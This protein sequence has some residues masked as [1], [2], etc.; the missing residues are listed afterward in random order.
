MRGARLRGKLTIMARKGVRPGETRDVED[1]L[2]ELYATPPAEFVSLRERLAAEAR[3]DGRPE[4]ARR[5]HAARRPTLA[6]WAANLLLHAQ[7]QESGRFLELGRALREAYAGLDAEG[8][9]ELSQQRRSIVSALSRQAAELADEA[10]HRLSDAARQDVEGTLRAVL[11]DQEAADLW[12]AGRLES[13]LSPPTDF[14]SASGAPHGR[15][16]A[17]ARREPAR[18]SAGPRSSRSRTQDELAE[19]RRRRREQLDEARRAAADADRRLR[20][21]RAGQTEAESALHRARER[22][23]QARERQDAAEQRVRE[24]QQDLRQARQD[25]RQADR[26]LRTADEGHRAAGEAVTGAEREARDAERAVRRPAGPPS[27]AE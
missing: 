20:D 6:A 5:I 8:I 13:A 4:D 10:G 23:Q 16:A 18:A 9:K 1:V 12:A 14:P 2:D 19:R 15:A 25:L 24:A 22:H 26:E 3:T 11:A 7:P 21:L 17:G 27:D